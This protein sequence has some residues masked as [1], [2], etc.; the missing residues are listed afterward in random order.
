MENINP[1]NKSSQEINEQEEP[2]LI[3]KT[4]PEIEK[5]LI[6]QAISQT[7]QSTAHLANL[8][9]TGSV[10]TFQLLSPIFSNNGTCDSIAKFMTG[11]LVALCGFSC[12]LLSFT[13]SFKDQN[14]NICYGF[15]T[16][17]GLWVI[18]G[19]ANLTAEMATKYKLKFIDFLHALMSMLVFAAVALF[20]ENVVNCF[21]P[22][23][24]DGMKEIL[25][26]VPVGIGVICSML[27]VVFPTKRHG[28]GFPV[29][30]I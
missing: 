3:N 10:L 2:L 5:T 6:Q 19:S 12:I 4:L 15:A 25:T 1:K 18:D 9:P 14:G 24:S 22:T 11:M 7:F 16:F 30:S 26:A 23:P 28:I 20:D 27:F 17:K 8:L 21:Y 13:D 29:T